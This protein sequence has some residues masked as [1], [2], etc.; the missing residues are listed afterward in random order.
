[1][2]IKASRENINKVEDALGAIFQAA[3]PS[4]TFIDRLEW[5]L[6]QQARRLTQAE[7]TEKIRRFP[8]WLY[9]AGQS[10]AWIG[11]G[12]L[13]VALMSWALTN[14]L[15]QPESQAVSPYPTPEV[16]PTLIVTSPGLPLPPPSETP[17]PPDEELE[18]QPAPEAFSDHPIV[19]SIAEEIVHPDESGPG[20]YTFRIDWDGSF[21]LG[22]ANPSGPRILKFSDDGELLLDI[23]L[24][25][26]EADRFDLALSYTSLWVLVM[27]PSPWLLRYTRMDLPG[28][29]TE[30]IPDEVIT[31]PP[32]LQVETGLSGVSYLDRSG[33]VIELQ[34]GLRRYRY[35]DM[36]GSWIVQHGTPA[37]LLPDDAYYQFYDP[38][39]GEFSTS[40]GEGKLLIHYS[41]AGEPRQKAHLPTHDPHLDYTFV[42]DLVPGYDGRLYMLARSEE[43]GLDVRRLHFSGVTLADEIPNSFPYLNR[44]AASGYEYYPS[45]SGEYTVEVITAGVPELEIGIYYDRIVLIR[46]NQLPWVITE[47]LEYPQKGFPYLSHFQWSHDE[48]YVYFYSTAY[49]SPIGTPFDM[50]LHRLEAS[51]GRVEP[52][53]LPDL[54]GRISISPDASK[55]VYSGDGTLHLVD[56]ETFETE[57]A[58]FDLHSIY[59]H[60]SKIA[61]APE[62]DMLVFSVLQDAANWDVAETS[63]VFLAELEP[64]RLTKLLDYDERWLTVHSWIDQYPVLKS[65]REEGWYYIDPYSGRLTPTDAV[66]EED[67]QAASHWLQFFFSSL[68]NRNYETSV[69]RYGGS[70]E[71]LQNWNPELA[72]DDYAG[73]LKNGC[74]VNGLEC[75]PVRRIVEENRISPDEVHFMVE[76]LNP[77]GSRLERG[78]CCGGSPDDFHIQTQFEYTV[79]QIDRRWKVMDLP[80]YL[81]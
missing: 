53:P 30:A 21:W 79:K 69:E 23:S 49:A 34:G 77:D 42:R 59:W 8:G 70:Y 72:P 62:G 13:L 68:W 24:E 12:F 35:N 45:P 41:E 57:S 73:L 32:E 50:E 5:E 19:F 27:E 15:P 78:A 58:A 75:L 29:S 47:R 61:W 2:M 9:S 38:A 67:S 16:I 71:I 74:E 25:G 43:S 44:L 65:E 14:L 63:A 4:P 81:P 60:I 48:R 46:P 3:Q 28:Y 37:I 54:S 39:A 22:A 66:D 6:D 31:L 55:V 56:L 52:I 26:I 17:L 20:A 10:A 1:M 11:A 51:N 76:F 18:Q 80:P 64:L 33:L 40:A 36:D 7:K